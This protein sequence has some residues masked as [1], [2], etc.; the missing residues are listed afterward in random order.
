MIH[1]KSWRLTPHKP[2]PLSTPA[3]A[4]NEKM[5]NMPDAMPHGNISKA[6][7]KSFKHQLATLT[8]SSILHAALRLRSAGDNIQKTI[9]N[10]KSRALARKPPLQ[11]LANR[12]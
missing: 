9:P 5:V 7:K 8:D 2:W 6:Q 3:A 11:A 1:A 10:G 12:S 4:T